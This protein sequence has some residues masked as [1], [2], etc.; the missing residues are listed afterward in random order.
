MWSSSRDNTPAAKRYARRTVG[1]MGVYAAINIAA[2]FGLFDG[3]AGWT[4]W[5]LAIAVA[6]P[7]IGQIWATLIYLNEA[8]EFVRAVMTKTFVA[9]T[10]VAFAVFC[11]WGFAESYADAPHAPGWLIYPLFW[12]AFGVVSPFVRTSR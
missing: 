3:R 2:I 1:F 4:A 10:G 12:A 7:V 6:L 11:V 5:L 8:D 9:A